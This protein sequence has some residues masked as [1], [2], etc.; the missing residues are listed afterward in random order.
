LT[1]KKNVQKAIRKAF[2]VS[3]K[4]G[5]ELDL[6]LVFK[7]KSGHNAY[8]DVAVHYSAE[9]KT[10]EEYFTD[11]E[12]ALIK[13]GNGRYVDDRGVLPERVEDIERCWESAEGYGNFN[14]KR[15]SKVSLDDVE[16]AIEELAEIKKGDDKEPDTDAIDLIL[17]DMAKLKDVPAVKLKS[18]MSRIKNKQRIQIG[19][20]KQ[21]FHKYVNEDTPEKLGDNELADQFIKKMGIDNLFF[22]NEDI[23]VY[24]AISKGLWSVRELPLLKH[25]VDTIC[26]NNFEKYGSS[27][28][29]SVTELTKHK[30]AISSDLL[31]QRNNNI[32]NCPNGN[33]TIDESTGE[34]TLQ[35]HNREY[36][37]TIQ[38]S[39]EYNSNAT[40][41]V[42]ETS[43]NQMFHGDKDK[44]DKIK[45]LHE[46]IGYAL[47]TS[48]KFN[49]IPVFFGYGA[50][51]K[52][53][54]IAMI[55]KIIGS[56]NTSNVR[57]KNMDN[58]YELAYM[59]HK[60]VNFCLEVGKKEIAPDGIMK[61][62]AEGEKV[63][64]HK[65]YG[66]PYDFIPTATLV[67]ALNNPLNCRDGAVGFLRRI[68]QIDF[69]NRFYKPH[70]WKPE[71]GE[72]FK[73]DLNLDDKL[74][75]EVEGVM[76]QSIKAYAQAVKKGAMT[77]P[78][79]VT[80]NY[81]K[82]RLRLN[83][84]E[85]FVE[86]QC[87][88]GN[89]EYK[90]GLQELFNSYKLWASKSGIHS[91]FSRGNFKEHL[92]GLGY[93]T[94]QTEGVFTFHGIVPVLSDGDKIQTQLSTTR[95]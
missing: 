19:D 7:L 46:L 87:Q 67:L 9:G 61:S 38:V 66:H 30:L 28:I 16:N 51:G 10:F 12:Q 86:E 65:K 3:K 23:Y 74:S 32:I 2:S 68:F 69:N 5:K 90:C 42:W 77:I 26:N 44:D 45:F 34:V 24:Q 83:Q 60:L 27:L 76:N 95:S 14:E 6:S 58:P 62:Q 92:I 21:D 56:N 37:S 52:S 8:M 71:Y 20:L 85:L 47:T 11:V 70:E 25:D 73:A 79:S 40:C 43:L 91:T 55:E 53:R 50:N 84:M 13:N 59:E 4:S 41:P 89:D 80:K 36:Y 57:L 82:L 39:T 94:T 1:E 33:I 22:T 63:T 88:S 18:L 15:V 72:M 54:V 31:N 64:C 75:G 49:L 93:R 81:D 29:N 35:P 78:T 48:T 17:K